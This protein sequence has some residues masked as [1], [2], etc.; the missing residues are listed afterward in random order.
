MQTATEQAQENIEFHGMI[1]CRTKNKSPEYTTISPD[2]GEF[3]ISQYPVDSGLFNAGRWFWS[4]DFTKIRREFNFT[5][6]RV[7]ASD[8]VDTRE[9]AMVG[10]L[11]AR[12]FWLDEIKTLMAKLGI[13]DYATGFKDGQYAIAKVVQEALS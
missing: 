3:R 4:V 12:G 5:H 7:D 9:E 1:W 6:L 10:C 11:T 2:V 8:I 13:G